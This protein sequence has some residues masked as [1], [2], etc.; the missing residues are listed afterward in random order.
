[1]PLSKTKEDKIRWGLS[2]W[3]WER[4]F[5]LVGDTRLAFCVDRQGRPELRK[6][7][8][9][10]GAIEQEIRCGWVNELYLMVEQ[11]VFCDDPILLNDLAKL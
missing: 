10:D 6:Q 2:E 8:L 5:A 11:I 1:M 9:E 4:F 7:T 3:P